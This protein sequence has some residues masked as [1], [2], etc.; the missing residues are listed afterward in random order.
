M[1]TENKK[2][3]LERIVDTLIMS[4][5]VLRLEQP[6]QAGG[7]WFT[8]NV[9]A[10]R[11][12]ITRVG[13]I[14]QAIGDYCMR[15]HEVATGIEQSLRE[16]GPLYF[17]PHRTTTE[18][19]TTL[20]SLAGAYRRFSSLLAATPSLFSTDGSTRPLQETWLQ[21]QRAGKLPDFN[22]LNTILMEQAGEVAS[23]PLLTTFAKELSVHSTQVSNHLEA[24]QTIVENLE[25]LQAARIRNRMIAGGLLC[26]ALIFG[27]VHSCNKD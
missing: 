8:G 24:L 11:N 26:V 3:L 15:A 6:T 21:V 18:S 12:A 16:S 2:Q 13:E 5:P 19:R 17:G 25:A 7:Q 27:I 14:S 9:P 10:I 23:N 4:A 22:R 1:A 20:T